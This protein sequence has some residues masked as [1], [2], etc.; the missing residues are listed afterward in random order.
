MAKEGFNQR[1]FVFLIFGILFISVFS[2]TV[3]A[4]NGSSEGGKNILERFFESVKSFFASLSEAVGGKGI[5]GEIVNGPLPCESPGDVAALWHSNGD[6]LD[7]GP[8]GND[9]TFVGNANANGAPAPI[10][11]SSNSF[12]FDGDGVDDWL[13]VSDSDSLDVGTSDFTVS[14]WIKV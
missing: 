1:A 3:L 6:A 8:N 4:G 13:R 10:S 2:A 12:S 9:G 14:A 5:T 7:A 11:G